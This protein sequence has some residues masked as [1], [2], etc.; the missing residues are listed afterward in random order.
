MEPNRSFDK[1]ARAKIDESERGGR[2]VGYI[3]QESDIRPILDAGAAGNTCEH[4]A[5]IRHRRNVFN[6]YRA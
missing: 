5:A 3:T 1:D 4:T 2:R 6:D